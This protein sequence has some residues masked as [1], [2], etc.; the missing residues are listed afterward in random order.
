MGEKSVN[1]IFVL[2]DCDCCE[3]RVGQRTHGKT[4]SQKAPAD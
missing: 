4:R 3:Q 1:M 2:K